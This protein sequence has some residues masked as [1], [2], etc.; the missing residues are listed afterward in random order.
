VV[1]FGGSK[2]LA[3]VATLVLARLLLPADFGV[4][5]ASLT[6]IAYLEIMLDLGMSSAIVYRQE[7]GHP[8][9]VT[10]AFTLNVGACAVLATLNVLLAPVLAAFFRAP[11]EV[12]LFRA[13]SI[14]I[15]LRGF[16]AVQDALLRR[17]L[18]FR[19]RA[20]ADI[21]RALSRGVIGVVLALAGFEAWALIWGLIVGEAA[22]TA[23][24]WSFTRFR[25]RLRFDRRTAAP[26]LRF[27]APVAGIALVSEVGTNS[28][29]LVIGHQ[30]G[31]I[32]LG[33]YLIAFR[34]PEL[35][36]SNVYW[37]FSSVAFPVFSHVG[38][39]NSALFRSAM[40]RALRL[41]T[42]FGFSVSVGLALVSRDAV[43]ALFGPQWS[44]ASGPMLLISLA[45]GL[46]CIGYASGDIFKAAGRP[47]ALL[48]V[49]GLC[50]LLMITGFLIA[51]PYGI[52][53]V[54]WVHLAVSLLEAILQ[55]NLANRIVGTT[56][57]Q[58]FAAM[59]PAI[60]VSS[61]IVL[62]A[63]P[64]RL[65]LEPGLVALASILIAGIAG[66]L[67]GLALSGRS[68]RHELWRLAYD[69]RR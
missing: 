32:A 9:S 40:L 64:V 66:A 55:L 39:G 63:L 7:K 62:V 18:R 49:S 48:W 34:L 12:A 17:D 29:Y 28:D 23:V 50:T 44:A 10:V 22:G 58:T 27:G 35:M 47:G 2:L 13:L 3:F 37:V 20:T 8:H 6:V 54:A 42:L 31:P 16:G 56:V 41:V 30:L 60:T 11:E 26:L 15:V 25:F 45:M 46:N 59:R 61:S 51:A 4:L 53:A 52:V 65:L 67:V 5:A 38:S 14:Y 21:T 69:L 1:S 57:T 19:D 43:P 68:V 36:L 33:L 24:A